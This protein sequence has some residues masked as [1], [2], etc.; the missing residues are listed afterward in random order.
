MNVV[1]PYIPFDNEFYK[2]P[3]SPTSEAAASGNSDNGLQSPDGVPDHRPL[4]YKEEHRDSGPSSSDNANGIHS[5][6]QAHAADDDKQPKLAPLGISL[7]ETEVI[8]PGY[9]PA[10]DFFYDEGSRLDYDFQGYSDP[11]DHD[12][13]SSKHK[14]DDDDE[15]ADEYF[16]FGSGSG[17]KKRD[18]SRGGSRTAS[19]N[20]SRGAAENAEI[21]FAE[22]QA[23][24]DNGPGNRAHKDTPGTPPRSGPTAEPPQV[25]RTPSNQTSD[26]QRAGD[27][28]PTRSNLRVIRPVSAVL[29]SAP[30]RDQYKPAGEDLATDGAA[31]QAG[32]RTP[33][34]LAIFGKTPSTSQPGGAPLQ[35]IDHAS[36]I[37]LGDHDNHLQVRRPMSSPA[38]NPMS[39]G[40]P[41]PMPASPARGPPANFLNQ[42]PSHMFTGFTSPSQSAATGGVASPVPAG[43]PQDSLEGSALSDLSEMD[44][45]GKYAPSNSWGLS[46]D[47]VALHKRRL[48]A[49]YTVH[50]P[51]KAFAA[52]VDTAWSLFGPRVWMELERKYR[53]K[54]SG[55]KPLARV[56]DLDSPGQK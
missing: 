15:D 41:F 19:G 16:G 4:A 33:P 43:M 24:L 8:A 35:N 34:H 10:V 40:V 36:S 54:T 20:G 5:H 1:T 48:L 23:A 27:K 38:I 29:R 53:G 45:T 18:G 26:G 50:C 28:T 30:L 44:S 21:S 56:S 13:I 14:Q 49:F 25:T 17:G 6:D 42:G 47:E 46:D 51:A 37:G 22:I 11:L 7:R 39:Q 3:L 31:V 2:N 32:A 55:F 9:T 52:N 12:I